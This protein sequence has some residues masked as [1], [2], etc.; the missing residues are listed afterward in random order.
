MR[1]KE[2]AVIPIPRRME[3]TAV[4]CFQSRHCKLHFGSLYMHPRGKWRDCKGRSRLSARSALQSVSRFEVST[5]D[6]RPFAAGFPIG[7]RSIPVGTRFC[8]AKS[9]VLYLCFRLT[10]ER[11]WRHTL[12]CGRVWQQTL[13]RGSR[14]GGFCDTKVTQM[15]DFWKAKSDWPEKEA[16]VYISSR[17]A[18]ATFPVSAF[19][20]FSLAMGHGRFPALADGSF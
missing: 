8:F 1:Q 14:T 15:Q 6:P 4:L 18:A 7:A 9:S 2:T 19:L 11:G 3:I 13:F 16:E 12:R 5:G 20:P 17:P 10:R